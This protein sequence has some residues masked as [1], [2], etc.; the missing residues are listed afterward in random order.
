M[1]RQAH[2]EKQIAAFS[3]ARSRFALTREPDSLA[4]VHT[5]RDLD[6]ITFHLV[7]IAAAQR[8]G[9]LRTM[10]CFFE[11]D[12]N[13]RLDVASSFG[14]SLPLTERTVAETCL[15]PAT[16]KRLEEIAESGPAEFEIDPAAVARGIAAKPATRLGVPSRWRL[17]ST[18][19]VPI[20]TELVVFLSFLRIAQDFVGFVKLL[21]FFFGGRFVL[22]DVGMVFTRELPERFADLVVAR[23]FRNAEGLIIIS[24][25]DCHC[26]VASFSEACFLSRERRFETAER[27]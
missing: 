10:Q 26:A 23:R 18:R 5:F 14:S 6:L 11:R 16:E 8:N 15:T 25:L 17:E 9:A 24:E 19:L 12:H 3:T 27:K 21:E 4:F 13:V 20:R 22:V 7:G 1:S 2:A